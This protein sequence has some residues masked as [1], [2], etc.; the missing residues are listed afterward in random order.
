MGPIRRR[1]LANQLMLP[2]KLRLSTKLFYEFIAQNSAIFLTL[3][4]DTDESPRTQMTKN[5]F[6]SNSSSTYSVFY[7]PINKHHTTRSKVGGG[8]ARPTFIQCPRTCLFISRVAICLP[9]PF[10]TDCE[11]VLHGVLYLVSFFSKPNASYWL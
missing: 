3:L 7:Q 5:F 9:A 2:L 8:S 10:I 6:G 4:C 11:V 1:N